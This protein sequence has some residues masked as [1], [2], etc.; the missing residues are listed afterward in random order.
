MDTCD[1]L[2]VFLDEGYGVEIRRREMTDT[3]VDLYERRQRHAGWALWQTMCRYEAVH[4]LSRRAI[5][6]S[7]YAAGF[8]IRWHERLAKRTSSNGLCEVQSRRIADRLNRAR[9]PVYICGR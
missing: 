9:L 2:V 8:D 3:Q 4:D 7:G 6:R 5:G 1:P